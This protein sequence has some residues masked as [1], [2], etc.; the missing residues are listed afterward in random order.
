MQCL[1]LGDD[2]AI[3]SCFSNVGSDLSRIK[4]WDTVFWKEP[5]RFYKD[6]NATYLVQK[7]S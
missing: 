5:L 7:I 6:K 1:E 3:H 4:S 2:D